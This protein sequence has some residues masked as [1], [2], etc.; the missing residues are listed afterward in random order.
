MSAI[1]LLPLEESRLCGIARGPGSVPLPNAIEGLWAFAGVVFV[2]S[3]LVVLVSVA[4]I[5]RSCSLSFRPRASLYVWAIDQARY[6]AGKPTMLFGFSETSSLA[7][8]RS[9]ETLQIAQQSS[10]IAVVESSHAIKEYVLVSEAG[11]GKIVRLEHG[12]FASVGAVSFIDATHVP[13]SRLEHFAA[14]AEYFYW[15]ECDSR[16]CR[17]LRRLG[18][19]LAK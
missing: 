10:T 8:G 5:G 7:I 16:G 14:N 9:D 11:A 18:R 6:A 3:K 13:G 4:C 12:G 15:T 2:S 1:T 19:S 17:S